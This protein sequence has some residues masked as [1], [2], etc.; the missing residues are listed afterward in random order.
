MLKHG[1]QNDLK[2]I[3]KLIDMFNG[4]TIN[5]IKNLII[6]MKSYKFILVGWVRFFVILKNN[7]FITIL[8]Y[9]SCKI[10]YLIY[11][12]CYSSNM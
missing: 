12:N 8:K 2:S 3:S 11:I 5:N 9:K 1:E 4:K 10:F 6:S 7:R